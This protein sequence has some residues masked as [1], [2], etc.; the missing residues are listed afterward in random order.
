[1][2]KFQGPLDLLL[3][4]IEKEELNI[5][6]V[7]ISKVTE[8]FFEHLNSFTEDRSDELADF[9]VIATKLVYLK[10]KNL[11]PFLYPEEDEGPSLAEQLKLYKKYAD[12]SK[13]IEQLWAAGRLAYGR[14]EPPVKPEGFTL[15]L[16][17]GLEDLKSAFLLL[18][19]RL[20][21][22]NALPQVSIDRTVSVKE[23]IESIYAA[24]KGLKN[25]SF[26]KIVEQAENRTDV[27]VSFLA[28]LELVKQEKVSIHQPMAFEDM[29]IK[30]M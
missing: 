30:R 21:P 5:T 22:L 17:A 27:I 19:K 7:T 6:D 26:K 8:Q 1:M 24:L 14:I 20:K 16:N 3:Q 9:L 23:K 29:M 15:P 2:D 25:I 13:N 11:L 4:L 12:A 18:L 10:S 28:I